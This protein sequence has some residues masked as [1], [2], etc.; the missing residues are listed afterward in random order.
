MQML[1][2]CYNKYLAILLGAGIPTKAVPIMDGIII[3]LIIIVLHM[4]F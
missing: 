4:L 3:L 2:A 1:K